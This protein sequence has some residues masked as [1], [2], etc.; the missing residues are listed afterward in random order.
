MSGADCCDWPLALRHLDGRRSLLS[1]CLLLRPNEE[2]CKNQSMCLRKESSESLA[3]SPCWPLLKNEGKSKL[4]II[5][6]ACPGHAFCCDTSICQSL[7]TPR[8]PRQI[9]P[10]IKAKPCQALLKE[11]VRF[12]LIY[13]FPLRIEEHYSESKDIDLPEWLA[14]V[15]SRRSPAEGASLGNDSWQKHPDSRFILLLF[16]TLFLTV[17]SKALVSWLWSRD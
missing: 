13:L 6:K 16:L 15:T 9:F 11:S 1:V 14:A 4:I 12:I 5:L 2:K 8:P 3:G 10:G 17:D 7:K